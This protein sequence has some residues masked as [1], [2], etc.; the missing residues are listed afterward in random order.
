MRL[1][2]D[3]VSGAVHEVG[4]IA[5]STHQRV[6]SLS[7]IEAV[8]KRVACERVGQLVAAAEGCRASKGKALH[9]R[10]ERVVDRGLHL[11]DTLVIALHNDIP[12]RI[13]HIGVVPL[14]AE[15]AVIARA[16]D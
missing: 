10:R 7:T 3:R 14:A 15:H 13:D 12:G 8:G 2:E 6:N 4:V 9:I 16:A 11:I 1:L 5:H